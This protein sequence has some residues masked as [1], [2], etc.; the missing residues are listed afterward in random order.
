MEDILT[1]IQVRVGQWAQTSMFFCTFASPQHAR[2]VL[3][4]RETVQAPDDYN[5]VLY[6]FLNF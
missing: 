5:Q 3:F 1:V 2:R 4:A 6:T